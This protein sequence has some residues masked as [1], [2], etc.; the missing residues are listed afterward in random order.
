L[1]EGTQTKIVEDL[2]DIF[3]R[4]KIETENKQFP[5]E[6]KNY[7][8]K[9]ETVPATVERVG[10]T[11]VE[12]TTN[13]Y[14]VTYNIYLQGTKATIPVTYTVKDKGSDLETTGRFK[15]G[16]EKVVGKLVKI[17]KNA[18]NNENEDKEKK[19]EDYSSFLNP[20]EQAITNAFNYRVSL[21]SCPNVEPECPNTI[22]IHYNLGIKGEYTIQD[23]IC[24]LIS[25]INK[26]EISPVID[27]F[28]NLIILI[29]GVFG[30]LTLF[31][32]D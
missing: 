11:P 29:A 30:A 18:E 13:T 17:K 5:V 26:P 24:V 16:E 28:G 21:F 23:P 14:N 22:T 31:R 8:G 4:S 32:R 20:A 15:L 7:V 19:E 1:Q 6:L 2:R 9:D 10:V 3:S 27:K 12:N 25:T